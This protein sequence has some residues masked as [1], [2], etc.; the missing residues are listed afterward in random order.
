MISQ[1]AFPALVP[2]LQARKVDYALLIEPWVSDVVAKGGYVAFSLDAHFEH[3][4]LTG[5]SATDATLAERPQIARAVVRALSEG[6]RVFYENEL[7]VLEIARA[8]FPSDSETSLRNG[9]KRMR[10]D[11][12]Y[13]RCLRVTEQ[14]WDPAIEVRRDIGDLPPNIRPF[15]DYVDNTFAIDACGATGQP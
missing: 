6:V 14:A 12:I 2:A 15:A 8:R 9:L 7:R 11:A 13:P 4:A 3:F 5:V 10:D 1:M